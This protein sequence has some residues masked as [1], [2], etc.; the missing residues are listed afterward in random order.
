MDGLTATPRI[1]LR[2]ET[3]VRR[4]S[5]SSTVTAGKSVRATVKREVVE[6]TDARTNF[7]R[8][9]IVVDM[10]KKRLFRAA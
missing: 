4:T 2:F 7:A 3:L 10:R 8:V 9:D 6:S 5:Q 1:Q